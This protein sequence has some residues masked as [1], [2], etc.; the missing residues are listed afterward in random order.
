MKKIDRVFI[1]KEYREKYYNPLEKEGFFSRHADTFIMALLYGFINDHRSKITGN[2]DG[3][4]LINNIPQEDYI[5]II[6]A[7]AVFAENGNL[8]ILQNDEKLYSIAEE[9]ANGGIALLNKDVFGKWK[10]DYSKKLETI[11]REKYQE[12]DL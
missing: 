7:V 11:L 3:L 10:E 4:I 9:Y 2:K 8:N 6:K 1:K 12:I 5:P